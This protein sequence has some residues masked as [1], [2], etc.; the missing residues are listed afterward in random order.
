MKN[1]Q[2]SLEEAVKIYLVK[3]DS[4]PYLFAFEIILSV[5]GIV[6]LFISIPASV[7]VFILLLGV[8]VNHWVSTKE[9]RRQLNSFQKLKKVSTV[10]EFSKWVEENPLVARKHIIIH[11]YIFEK[12]LESFS[13]IGLKKTEWDFL[14]A[15]IT[16]F[17]EKDVHP[18]FLYR[19]ESPFVKSPP[20]VTVFPMISLIVPLDE[21]SRRLMKGLFGKKDNWMKQSYE[22][23]ETEILGIGRNQFKLYPDLEFGSGWYENS[24]PIKDLEEKIEANRLYL[25][26]GQATILV[27]FIRQEYWFED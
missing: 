25:S 12:F 11:E 19:G 3:K 23:G 1:S 15:V 16:L 21:Q 4:L 7:A 18:F 6:C 26:D 22:S 2:N 10:F 17:N 24:A 20:I 8:S 5:A 13:N 27:D 9:Y 14:K